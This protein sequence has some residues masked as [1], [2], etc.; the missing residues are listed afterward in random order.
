[1]FVVLAQDAQRHGAALGTEG[2]SFEEQVVVFAERGDTFLRELLNGLSSY[3][4]VAGFRV[5]QACGLDLLRRARILVV[6]GLEQPAFTLFAIEQLKQNENERY[7][8]LSIACEAALTF[9]AV[10]QALRRQS[11]L[12]GIVS[13]KRVASSK[14]WTKFIGDNLLGQIF[15]IS[16]YGSA[17]LSEVITV[18]QRIPNPTRMIWMQGVFGI[19]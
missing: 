8:W 9:P 11:S 16:Y 18:F 19:Y 13:V 1:V 5:A 14:T 10:N 3:D 2:R 4:A 12:P 15:D 7:M 17:D 6:R